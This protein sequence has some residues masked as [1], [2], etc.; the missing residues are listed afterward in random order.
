VYHI[1]EDESNQQG[2]K[3]RRVLRSP[4]T[5]N[6]WLYREP[7]Q[8]GCIIYP[9][10]SSLTLPKLS[11]LWFRSPDSLQVRWGSFSP[12]NDD[13]AVELTLGRFFN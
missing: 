3:A 2:V 12:P 6:R 4:R 11:V 13:S 1:R 9:T 5:R 8:Q 7:C 10:K